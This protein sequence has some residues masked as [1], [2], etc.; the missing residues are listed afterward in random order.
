[1]KTITTLL[2]TLFISAMLFAANDSDKKRAKEK[3]NVSIEATSA[4]I[5]AGVVY[6]ENNN[7]TLA[8]AAITVDG[9]KYYS[10]LDGKFSL[11][12]SKKMCEITVELISYE[13]TRIVI[14]AQ[15]KNE[16]ISIHLTQK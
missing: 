16:E 14:D 3:S 7:E 13:P 8:G 9:K 4:T 5:I 1:M 6:D 11:A 15:A 12:I 10:D 2:V